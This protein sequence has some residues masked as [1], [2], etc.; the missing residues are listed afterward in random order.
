MASPFS[1]QQLGALSRDKQFLF[2]LAVAITLGAALVGFLVQGKMGAMFFTTAAHFSKTSALIEAALRARDWDGLLEAMFRMS[3]GGNEPVVWLLTLL[4]AGLWFWILIKITY[5]AYQARAVLFGLIALTLGFAS[6]TVTLVSAIWHSQIQGFTTDGSFLGDLTYYIGSVGFR[7]ETIKLL[8]FLPLTP[9]LY[10]TRE[11][12]LILFTAACVGLGFAAQE[13]VLYANLMGGTLTRYVTA[14][15]LHIALTAILGYAF[16]RFLYTPRQEWERLIMTYLGV[17]VVHGLY[18]TTVG[19]LGEAGGLLGIMLFAYLCY[20]FFEL[21]DKS[22]PEKRQL[23]SPLGVFVPGCAMIFGITF[24]AASGA[25]SIRGAIT[26]T[27]PE[28]LGALPLM[29]IYINRFRDA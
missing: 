13:N 28:L 27:T 22:C 2:R 12:R 21:M 17:I 3:Y 16:C 19:S 24:V 10:R 20:Y 6:T 7:E 4:V 9:F 29:F 15:F 18:N 14:N 26:A 25:L 23:V 11:P 1:P 5:N 8:F